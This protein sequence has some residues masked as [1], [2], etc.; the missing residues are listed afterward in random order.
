MTMGPD[1]SRWTKVGTTD[2]A[3]LY[4][5]EPGILAVVPCDESVDTEETATQCIELQHR[6]WRSRGGRG[7]AVIFMDRVR[8]S[9]ADAR[10]V[11][12]RLPDPSLITGFALIGGTVFGRAV[13][14]V[15]LG[16]SRPAA[17]TKMF[18]DLERALAWL[19]EIGA[20]GQ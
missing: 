18:G 7:G 14:S 15:F 2:N 6:H 1:V 16:L 9:Q 12:G 4:E 11:Y 13:G 5:I 19:R 20:R 10:K 3:D 8:D 17:P